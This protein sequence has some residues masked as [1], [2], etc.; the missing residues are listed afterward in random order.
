MGFSFERNETTAE[1]VRRIALEQLDDARREIRDPAMARHEVVHQVRKRCKKLRGLLR[2]VRP[3]LGDTYQQENA[4]FRDS[5]RALSDIRDAQALIESCDALLEHY[6]QTLPKD[7]FSELQERLILHRD[8]QS[9]EM[10]D[11]EERLEKFLER[12]EQAR[13]RVTD[14]PLNA[15]SKK[16]TTAATKAC[17]KHATRAAQRITT[18]G[19]SG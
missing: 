15:A 13:E 18:S 9:A 5:A 3:C 14:W 10:T 2:L 4:W 17:R 12:M 7:I 19:A 8:T 6:S 1:G 11:V 16:P